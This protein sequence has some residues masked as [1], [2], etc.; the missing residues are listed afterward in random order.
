MIVSAGAAVVLG[1]GLAGGASLRE[2]SSL[3]SAVCVIG[4]IWR[5]VSTLPEMSHL[6]RALSTVMVINLVAASVSQYLLAREAA[7]IAQDYPVPQNTVGVWLVLGARVTILALVVAWP[8]WLNRWEWPTR[9]TR[10]RA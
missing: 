9:P 8:R 5:G 3:L 2:F 7:R 4:L 10:R 6:A 1:A